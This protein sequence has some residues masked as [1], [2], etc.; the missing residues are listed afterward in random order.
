MDAGLK[1]SLSFCKR[2]P[3]KEILAYIL[4]AFKARTYY[5]DIDAYIAS[6]NPENAA[7]VDYWYAKYMASQK[8]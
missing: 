8:Q 2:N 4:G 5:E 6:K 3:M 1:M 7:Q